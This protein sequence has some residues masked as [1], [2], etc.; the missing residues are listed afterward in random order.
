MQGVWLLYQKPHRHY[1]MTCS[2]TLR[3]WLHN[4]VQLAVL[5]NRCMRGHGRR[6]EDRQRGGCV[7]TVLV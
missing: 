6:Q 4:I 3:V 7:V 2:L 1:K 5:K